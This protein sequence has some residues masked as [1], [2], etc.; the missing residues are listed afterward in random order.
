MTINIDNVD[1]VDLRFGSGHGGYW[2]YIPKPQGGWEKG[3]EYSPKEH[4]EV[5]IDMWKNYVDKNKRPEFLGHQLT[6]AGFKDAT[7]H[8]IGISDDAPEKYK[9]LCCYLYLNKSKIQEKIEPSAFESLVL[10]FK[11]RE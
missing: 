7:I 10:N 3:F 8:F 9:E 1:G 11:L 4:G 2:G 6:D 5:L